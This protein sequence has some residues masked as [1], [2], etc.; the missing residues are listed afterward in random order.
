MITAIIIVLLLA[1]LLS[2]I[3]HWV[4]YDQERELAKQFGTGL[5]IAGIVLIVVHLVGVR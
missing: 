5:L 2:T 1:A 3:G 4:D